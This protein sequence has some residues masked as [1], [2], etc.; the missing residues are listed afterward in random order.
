M[1]RLTFYPARG[2]H[3]VGIDDGGLLHGARA[4]G[5]AGPCTMEVSSPALYSFVFLFLAGGGEWSPDRLLRHG[6][7]SLAGSMYVRCLAAYVR[8]RG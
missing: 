5:F 3:P 1:G 6:P 8:E 7:P 4:A 2:V